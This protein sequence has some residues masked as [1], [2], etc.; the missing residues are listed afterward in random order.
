M[1]RRTPT[2][3]KTT[4]NKVEKVASPRKAARKPNADA[5][6]FLRPAFTPP[7]PLDMDA[8]QLIAAYRTGLF[9]PSAVVERC[10]ERIRQTQP[11]LN[12]LVEDNFVL[13]RQEALLSDER[14]KRGEPLGELDGIPMTIKD[15]FDVRG[16]KTTGGMELF[17][18]NV[19]VQD[20]GAV[21]RLR[22]A[23]AI[24]LGK[25]NTPA[26]CFCQETDN[27]LHGRTNNPWNPDCTAGGSSGGEATAVSIG[28]APCGLGSDIGGS[29][30]IPAHFCGVVGFKPAPATFPYEGH[31]P[32]PDPASTPAARMLGYGPLTRS[33][34]DARLLARVLHPDGPEMSPTSPSRVLVIGEFGDTRLHPDVHHVLDAGRAAFSGLDTQDILPP[35]LPDT[36]MAWQRIMSL[37]AGREIAEIAYPAPLRRFSGHPLLVAADYLLSLAGKKTRCHPYLSWGLLGA[38]MFAPSRREWRETEAVLDAGFAWLH[39]NL[40]NG[41][42]LLSPV[43]PEPAP[44][45]GEVYRGIFSLN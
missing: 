20:A 28:A 42:V 3:K 6:S 38:F 45:H 23:G 19:A 41:G 39:E 5:P 44:A 22:A 15:S 1:A 37:N 21:A 27:T 26:L 14:W 4:T 35:F 10:L 2:N 24:F 9:R 12:F 34:R 8:T 33:V 43:Y 32:S 25:T 36:S 7:D 30:R 18:D 11:A 17:R 16:M 31:L 40:S 13:A 29:I